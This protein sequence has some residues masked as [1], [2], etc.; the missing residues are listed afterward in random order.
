M[1]KIATATLLAVLAGSSA[2]FAVEPIPGSITYNGNQSHLP[3][4]PVGSSFQHQFVGDDGQ[5]YRETYRVNAIK[6]VD[7]VGRDIIG[8]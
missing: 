5:Q 1:T 7:L 6:G 2:A 8:D 3:N 4:S